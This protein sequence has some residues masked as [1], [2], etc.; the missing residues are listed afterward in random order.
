MSFWI[1]ILFNYKP[2]NDKL[3]NI[4]NMIV[5][6]KVDQPVL[7]DI[8]NV[9]GR[10]QSHH[11]QPTKR[12]LDTT[13]SASKPSILYWKH[14][15]QEHSN[16]FTITFIRLYRCVRFSHTKHTVWDGTKHESF[17]LVMAINTM[18]HILKAYRNQSEGDLETF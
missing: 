13:S 3:M 12:I 6:R 16:L 15:F 2:T 5:F 7:H 17:G 18:S 1:R 4:T 14:L 9:H 10:S 11:P 8:L